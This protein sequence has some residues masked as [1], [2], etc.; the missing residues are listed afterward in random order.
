MADW[1]T[2][3]ASIDYHV[4]VDRHYYSVP[5]QLA[6]QQME[7]RFTSRTVEIFHAGKRVASH[8]R[9]APKTFV[10]EKLA[11]CDRPGSER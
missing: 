3:P 2:V 10:Y 1:K 9:S 11:S 6:G 7:A 8:V 5:Y 4:E